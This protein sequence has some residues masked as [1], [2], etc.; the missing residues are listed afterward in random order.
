MTDKAVHLDQHREIAAQKATEL[1]RATHD[2]LEVQLLAATPRTNSSGS[3]C[4]A[5]RMTLATSANLLY[6][7]AC[8]QYLGIRVGN[9]AATVL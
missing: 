3:F 7:N 1:R 4:M 6:P 2:A 8:R 5:K 9:I